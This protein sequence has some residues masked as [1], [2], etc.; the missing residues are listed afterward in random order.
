MVVFSRGAERLFAHFQLD[1]ERG[2][3]LHLQLKAS[4][5]ELFESGRFDGQVVLPSL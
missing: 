3:L 1:V 5:S 4:L 2:L